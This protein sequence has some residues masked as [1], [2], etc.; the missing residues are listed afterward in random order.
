MR[1][2]F[3]RDFV[4]NAAVYMLKVAHNGREGEGTGMKFKNLKGKST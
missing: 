3:A 1:I 2:F 4:R